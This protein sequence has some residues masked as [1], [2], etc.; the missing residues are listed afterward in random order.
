MQAHLNATRND[1]LPLSPLKL[2]LEQ[3]RIDGVE[4]KMDWLHLGGGR[5][6]ADDSL[7]VFKSRFSDIRFLFKVWKY[8]HNK[9]VYKA[10]IEEKYNGEAYPESAFFPLYRK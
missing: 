7:F 6:G 4:K 10:L 5:G 2:V 1:F 8:V 3:A 9:A